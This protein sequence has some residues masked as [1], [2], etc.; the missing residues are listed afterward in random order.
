LLLLMKKLALSLLVLLVIVAGAGTILLFRGTLKVLEI[1]SLKMEWGDV[2]SQS[3]EV[4]GTVIV[5]NSLPMPLGY[6]SVGVEISVKF[7]DAHA[8]SLEI[9][10]LNLGQGETSFPISGAF[11]QANLPLWW[12]EFVKNGETLAI[13]VQPK[14]RS[15]L[16]GRQISTNL[17]STRIN[18]EIPLMKK[19][20][21]QEPV[22]MKVQAGPAV[23]P[24][25]T[26]ESWELHWGKVTQQKTSVLGTIVLKNETPVPLPLQ[27]FRL[28]IDMNEI[29]V[30]PDANLTLSQ[31]LLWP[32]E[33]V[34]LDLDAQVDNLKLV[35]WW[36]SHL[37]QAERTTLT[38]RMELVVVL[39][40]GFFGS[41]SNIE[42]PLVLVPGFACHIT[43]DIMAIAN[44]Q[45]A[46]KL[47]METGAEPMASSVNCFPSDQMSTR[48]Y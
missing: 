48:I 31:H 2:T 42:L 37:Q 13:Q 24:V 46:Q 6:N 34:T 35:E 29:S 17:P 20:H 5:D 36:T 30:I 3:T 26:V 8:L 23:L 15:T 39:P 44:Y 41:L 12:P 11:K 4:N 25:L 32:K 19:M 47:E 33:S 27:G 45:L 9:P 28:G 40:S 43:T 16:L 38:T 1:K 14:A 18:V 22:T 21:S 10:H 7:Y